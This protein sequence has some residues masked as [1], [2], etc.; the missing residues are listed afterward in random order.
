MTGPQ[1]R[2]AVFDPGFLEDLN[3]WTRTDRKRALGAARSSWSKRYS[4]TLSLASASPNPSAVN[5]PAD[6]PGGST[7]STA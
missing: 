2:E 5:S 1:R 4:A 3:Y 7:A 6:G